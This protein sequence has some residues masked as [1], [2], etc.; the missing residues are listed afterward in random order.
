MSERKYEISITLKS[1]L[2]T[3]SGYSY[4]GII[5]SDVCY[6]ACGL[7]YIA[8]RRLKGCLREAAELI[9][10]TEEERDRM[11]GKRGESAAKGVIIQ[12]AYIDHYEEIRGDIE[13]L[14]K[15]FR[16]YITPQRVLEQFTTVKAQTKIGENGAAKDNT[17]RY[18]RT[19][20][21]YSPMESGETEMHFTAAV[22][23]P[24]SWEEDLANKF[25]W[26]VKALRNIG[27]NRNRGL[28][29]VRCTFDPVKEP[30]TAGSE[31]ENKAA[32]D[33]KPSE[34]KLDEDRRYVLRYAVKNLSPLV[35]STN[36]DFKTE[37]YISGRSVLGFFAAAYLKEPEKSADSEEFEQLFLQDQVYFGGLYPAESIEKG[38]KEDKKEA[39]M[40]IYYPAPAF[41]NQLKKTKKYVNVSKEVP[42]NEEDC[43][44]LGIETE[45]AS[46]NGNQPKRLRGKFVC[47]KDG[48]ILVKE[49]ATDIVYHHTKKVKR[50]GKEEQDHL[51][52]TEV[53]REQQT[54]AGEI[55]G[56]GKQIEIIR[57]L[58]LDHTLRFGKSKSS[59]YG[60]CILAGEPEIE[61]AGGAS[62]VYKA[63]SRILAVLESDGIFTD[64][65]GY[66]VRCSE[67]RD[68]IRACLGIKENPGTESYSELE[69]GILTGY[70]SKWNLKRP[71]V[72]V[73]KAGS[74]FEF[75]LTEDYIQSEEPVWA[76]EKNGEGFGRIRIIENGED[77]RDCRMEEIEK[78]QAS[79]K[80]P[81]T[82]MSL[83]R[84]I[85]IEEARERLMR[86]AV[87]TK[88][89]FRNPAV[90][91]RVTLMLSESI[92]EYPDDCEARYKDFLKRIS[93]IKTE[94]TRKRAETVLREKICKGEAL[95]KNCLVYWKQVEGLKAPYEYFLKEGE[96]GQKSFEQAMSELWSEYLMAAFVQ[97]KY[98]LKHEEEGHE[99]D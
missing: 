38:S 19:V 59:Q 8:A 95:D 68:Q 99:E 48:K 20:N 96:T 49:P 12:N 62:K 73:I 9:G 58:L 60:T 74:S 91:G 69:A 43:K 83:F 35:M 50:Q 97:E 79:S 76:G 93:S 82:A 63:G 66:T 32:C 6:D 7:P 81:E 25:E 98:N 46:G 89:K 57:D 10:I 45:Y 4:A 55:I 23:L 28:G 77:D 80:K 29:S 3:G 54:F 92:Q 18:T 78:A 22:F 86:E 2:C 41:I 87:R 27:M 33:K 39:C 64:G 47:M 94:E 65:A 15:E 56:N 42:K 44:K 13:G 70:Y 72:P 61:G 26:T 16:E 84:K 67:V 36:D 5:D 31:A 52:T 90:L 11:F 24:D 30:E 53:L 37:K 88:L 75:I 71:A 17:L 51:Y 14:G 1:D 34:E 21:H 40:E 85:M